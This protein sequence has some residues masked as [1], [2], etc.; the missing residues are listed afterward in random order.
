[1]F[2]AQQLDFVN[3]TVSIVWHIKFKSACVSVADQ[4]FRE[5]RRQ[6]FYSIIVDGNECKIRGVCITLTAYFF[7]FGGIEHEEIIIDCFEENKRTIPNKKPICM[8][9]IDGQN[10]K[11]L[12]SEL[13]YV[14]PFPIFSSTRMYIVAKL[15][16]ILVVIHANRVTVG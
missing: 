6:K 16:V 8:G 3:S 11:L 13:F 10:G 12:V 14:M 5:P 2:D 15:S 1:M 7:S 4:E 9:L